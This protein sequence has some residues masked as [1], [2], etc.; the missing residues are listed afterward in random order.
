MPAWR[1]RSI[2]ATIIEMLCLKSLLSLGW[3][4]ERK[5]KNKN[6]GSNEDS[7]MKDL[8]RQF[9]HNF[10]LLLWTFLK[11]KGGGERENYTTAVESRTKRT[12]VVAGSVM[13]RKCQLRENGCALQQWQQVPAPKRER[14]RES[15][16]GFLLK[17]RPPV[18]DWRQR[19]LLRL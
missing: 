4:K 1:R 16:L 10:C 15:S 2:D 18:A 5:R 7:E 11:E 19:A 12:A 3:K 8:Q 17:R 14:E 6:V 13:L 9:E